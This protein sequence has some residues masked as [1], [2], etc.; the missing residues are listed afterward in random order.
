DTIVFG[1]KKHDAGDY[2]MD[3]LEGLGG[4]D[5]DKAEHGR[6]SPSPGRGG[7]S[8]FVFS[9]GSARYLKYGTAVYPLNLWAVSDFDRDKYRFQVP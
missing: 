8:N 5:A 4:N 2:Y 7:G 9:D 6:H 1:E 3:M